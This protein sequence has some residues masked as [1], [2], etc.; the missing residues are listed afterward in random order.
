MKRILTLAVLALALPASVRPLEPSQPRLMLIK[1]VPIRTMRLQAQHAVL[2]SWYGQHYA[3]RATASGE[4]FNPHAMTAAHRTLKL[5]TRIRVTNPR[6]GASV[7][8]VVNDRGPFVGTRELD[9]SE[10]AAE[11]LGIRGRGVARLLVEAL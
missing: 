7:V 5:G 1:H 3:G 4:P 6:T 9:V 10:A 8:L 2:A 11:V